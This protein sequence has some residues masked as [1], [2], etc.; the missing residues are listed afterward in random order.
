M[1]TKAKTSNV[2][3]VL[4]LA[5]SYEI[6]FGT[7]SYYYAIALS[8]LFA[9]LAYFASRKSIIDISPIAHIWYLVFPIV[10]GLL[11]SC[12]LFIIHNNGNL[13]FGKLF[14]RM[15]FYSATLLQGVC[16]VILYGL[17]AIDLLFDAAVI[18]YSIR[19]VEYLV[20]N[21]ILSLFNYLYVSFSGTDMSETSILEAHEVTF[22]FGLFFIY[23]ISRGFLRNKYRIL[24]ALI[25][26]LLGYKR[27]MIPGLVIAIISF[28]LVRKVRLK[29]FVVAL[30]T[31]LCY[32]GSL[33]WLF[34][35][36]NNDLSDLGSKYNINFMGRVSLNS[37]ISKEYEIGPSYMGKGL[38]YLDVWSYIHAIDTNN[39]ALHNDTALM[40]IELGFILFAMYFIYY[41]YLL[42]SKARSNIKDIWPGLFCYTI[43]CWTTDNVQVYFNYQVVLMSMLFVIVSGIEKEN[44]FTF[45]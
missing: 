32:T 41:L 42:Y 10:I 40:Y 21:G 8:L 17:K 18:F 7:V 15:L 29:R 28:F 45:I 39:I 4:C 13:A 22:A 24:I 31:M 2:I 27:I 23:Y 37:L 6:Y 1:F 30:L 3:C 44:N 33:A 14:S 35:V 43:I 26:I 16:L 11:Y 34:L 19:V 20:N 36:K 5:L 12:F 25:F 38:G 9:L